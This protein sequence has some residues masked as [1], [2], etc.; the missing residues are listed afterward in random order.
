M[1]NIQKAMASVDAS[2]QRNAFDLSERHLF[3]AKVGQLLP[4]YNKQ[5]VPGDYFEID[6]V[7]FLRTMPINTASFARMRQHLE[8]FFVPYS[9]LWHDFPQ[10][11]YQRL[12]ATRN[13]WLGGTGTGAPVLSTMSPYIS[14]EDLYANALAQPSR[15]VDGVAGEHSIPEGQF[16]DPFGF[17]R[18]QNHVRLLDLL[19]YGSLRNMVTNAYDNNETRISNVPQ[20]P[21]SSQH[22]TLWPLLAYQKIYND[23][24]RNPL[25]DT[26]LSPFMFNL[27]DVPHSEQNYDV[28]IV[29]GGSHGV[30]NT[31]IVN[32]MQLRYRGWKKDYFTGMFPDAQFGDVSM[33]NGTSVF[34]MRA[35]EENGLSYLLTT[36]ADDSSNGTVYANRNGSYQAQYIAGGISAYDIRRAE[37]M[38]VWK[39]K[40]MRAGYRTQ[41]QQE[42]HFGVKSRYI[43]DEHVD[44]IGGVSSVIDINEVVSTSNDK[45]GMESAN[46]GLGALAGKGISLSNGNK[47][48]YKVKDDGIIMAIF[49]IVPESEYAAFG[50]QRDHTR[51]DPFDYY[52]PAFQNV[53][54][55]PIS[56]SDV[57]ILGVGYQGQIDRVIGYAPPFYDMKLGIDK[58]H[59][60][61]IPDVTL[62]EPSDPTSGWM[63][64]NVNG[65]SLTAFNIA[66]RDAFANS[67]T[68]NFFYVNPHVTDSIFQVAADSYD[69]SDGFICNMYLDIKAVRPMS[70]LGLLNI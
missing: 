55:Q 48:R 13:K 51:I 9:Q 60:E 4:V 29:R 18:V 19:G 45:T 30:Y 64:Q 62:S 70:V 12:D 63:P 42:A 66:R 33:V 23:Y 3:S 39:E 40:T 22:V 37:L 5:V 8:F 54:F 43:A 14:L 10:M 57:S 36:G 58:V 17:D 11:K 35:T 53:G 56:K 34:K 21:Y 28:Q 61:F 38:Q 50:L 67:G 59:G 1:A 26:P 2:L 46:D 68:I 47:I 65:G 20:T 44:V 24:Y 27:D 69:T 7:T 31:A 32:M 6:P 52:T 49:S 16:R 15:A 41:A 25:F